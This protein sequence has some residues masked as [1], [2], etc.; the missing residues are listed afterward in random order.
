MSS[1]LLRHYKVLSVCALLRDSNS[2]DTLSRIQSMERP[3]RKR[4]AESYPTVIMFFLFF[5][6]IVLPCVEYALNKPIHSV[7]LSLVRMGTFAS[8]FSELNFC[9]CR[10]ASDNSWNFCA[11]SSFAPF[12][13]HDWLKLTSAFILTNLRYADVNLSQTRICNL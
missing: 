12:Q 6:L 8:N 10:Q 5:A 9:P 11:F 7:P 4:Q 3:M 13:I 2:E 1:I